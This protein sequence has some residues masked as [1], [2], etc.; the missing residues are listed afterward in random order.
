MPRFKDENGDVVGDEGN[1]ETREKEKDMKEYEKGMKPLRNRLTSEVSHYTPFW[2]WTPL[3]AV[4]NKIQPTPQ[5]SKSPSKAEKSQTGQAQPRKK[6]R[7]LE[8]RSNKKQEA[9]S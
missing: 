7:K 5:P 2:P 8:I 6:P 1:E 4:M 9:T 3:T